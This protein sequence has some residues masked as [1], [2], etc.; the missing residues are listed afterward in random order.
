MDL[1]FQS[2]AVRLV[3]SMLDRTAKTEPVIPYKPDKLY[4]SGDLTPD[5]AFE[6][7]GDCTVYRGVFRPLPR[8]TPESA[9]VPS[10]LVADY[11]RALASCDLVKAHTVIVYAAQSADS[12]AV[13][14]EASLAPHTA[15]ELHCTHSLSK[16]LTG[17]GVCMA[18]DEGRLELDAPLTRYFPKAPLLGSVRTKGITV[19]DLYSM[20]VAVAFNETGSV[21]DNEWQRAY[22]ESSFRDRGAFA[23]NSM[24]SFMLAALLG[25]IW[26]EP[27]GAVL[28][29]RLYKPL[30]FG[31]V[32][33]EKSPDGVEKGGFGLYLLPEDMLKLGVL[34]MRYG[35]WFGERIVSEKSVRG[36]LSVRTKVPPETSAFFDYGGHVWV[37]EN[38]R[39]WLLNGMFGQNVAVLPDAGLVIG[40]T[41]GNSDMFQDNAFFD[42]TRRFFADYKKREALPE[43]PLAYRRLVSLCRSLSA[44]SPEVPAQPPFVPAPI[45]APA[46]EQTSRGGTVSVAPDKKPDG[47]ALSLMLAGAPYQGARMP[48]RHGGRYRAGAR[49]ADMRPAPV[50]CRPGG[51]DGALALLDGV[52]LAPRY[53]SQLVLLVKTAQTEGAAAMTAE[54]QKRA[55]QP[56][57]PSLMPL[58]LQA[59]QN[60]WQP[61]IDEI[62][63]RCSADGF[64][65]VFTQEGR[66]LSVPVAVAGAHGANAA[67]RRTTLDLGGERYRV[68]A[69]GEFALDETGAAVLTLR[70]AFTETANVRIVRILFGRS[71]ISINFSES[72]GTEIIFSGAG[73]VAAT[74]RPS[75]ILE[76][77]VENYGDLLEYRLRSA[78]DVSAVV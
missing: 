6:D 70:V 12:G 55:K 51:V 41:G 19:D 52:R 32:I 17:L 58:L 28:A 43:N 1:K 57:G 68:G 44:I 29:R 20:R 77:L 75:R 45:K 63:F 73:V 40:V 9:G 8:S 64:C 13:I 61:Q 22:L 5:G 48:W 60:N 21:T 26:G 3:L 4:T 18:V 59:L 72:P 37:G 66:E 65:A 56:I 35:D 54:E 10:P 39:I 62:S 27:M 15:H 49:C 31:P 16:S 24:N 71:G 2:A 25:S 78:L 33:W 23:Y 7:C 36:A 53:S 11:I 74:L 14:A 67:V 46:Q 30:G 42:I 69:T 38:P 50:A 76:A 34:Y 47:A